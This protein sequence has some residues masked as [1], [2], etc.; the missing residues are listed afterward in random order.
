MAR[1]ARPT[2]VF[3]LAT[4]PGLP[5]CP[6]DMTE[7]AW[8]RLVFDQVCHVYSSLYSPLVFLTYWLDL[9]YRRR[10]GHNVASAPA[11]MRQLHGRRG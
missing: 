5:P 10:A 7:P 11:G 8:V 1:S 2:W 9:S 4:V 3:A 6:D